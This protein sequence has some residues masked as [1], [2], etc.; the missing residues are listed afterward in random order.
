MS[1]LPIIFSKTP[2]VSVFASPYLSANIPE[3]G[4]SVPVTSYPKAKEKLICK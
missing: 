2:S 1:K 3:N 4:A